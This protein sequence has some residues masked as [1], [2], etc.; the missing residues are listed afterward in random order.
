MTFDEK[1]KE[2]TQKYDVLLYIDCRTYVRIT[3]PNTVFYINK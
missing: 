2:I 3:T 1:I